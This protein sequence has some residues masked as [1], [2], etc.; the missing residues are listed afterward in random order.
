M[1]DRY[2]IQIQDAQ[3]ATLKGRGASVMGYY[4]ADGNLAINKNYFDSAKMNAAYDRCAD[5]GFHPSRGNKSGI[6]AV[7]AHEM[8]H[9]LTDAAGVNSGA[10]SW[11]LDSTANS[12][13][14][15]AAK[16]AGYRSTKTFV[17][18]ISG[19]AKQNHAEAVAEAFADVYC[20][21]NKAKKESRAIV[22][23]LN[24]HF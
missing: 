8:G 17:S 6:E 1:Y 18:K 13:V 12:I 15:Q 16:D 5:S 2:G 22:N 19:Y 21:G 7:V 3:I 10:G 11:Q 9:R 23:V 4:D 14:K 24:K 20:N